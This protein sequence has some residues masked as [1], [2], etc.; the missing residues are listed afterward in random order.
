M[1]L[2]VSFKQFKY[3]HVVEKQEKL[4]LTLFQELIFLE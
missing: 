4:L 3:F 2:S 1:M